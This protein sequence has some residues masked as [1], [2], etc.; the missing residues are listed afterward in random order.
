MSDVEIFNVEK[1]AGRFSHQPDHTTTLCPTEF[2]GSNRPEEPDFSVRLQVRRGPNHDIRDLVV[3][4]IPSEEKQAGHRVERSFVGLPLT[5]DPDGN[6][7]G[8]DWEEGVWFYYY[9]EGEKRKYYMLTYATRVPEKPTEAQLTRI[10]V[11][12][13]VEPDHSRPAGVMT[14]G[15]EEF[16]A[17][18]ASHK[19][20]STIDWMASLRRIMEGG[21]GGE[22]VTAEDISAHPLVAA[23]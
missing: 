17:F 9:P 13:M 12:E 11:T 10:N 6:V 22:P 5:V 4:I 8:I 7:T 16:N 20:L 2:Y 1:A 23:A 15:T 3:R 21:H 19:F 18:I 14:R